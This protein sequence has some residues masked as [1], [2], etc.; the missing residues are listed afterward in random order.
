VNR[1][2]QVL[3]LPEAQSLQGLKVAFGIARARSE[4]RR[5][6]QATW[7]VPMPDGWDTSAGGHCF[8]NMCGDSIGVGWVQVEGPATGC[9]GPAVLR[10]AGILDR[11]QIG[12]IARKMRGSVWRA[13]R[14]TSNRMATLLHG[15][16]GR[17]LARR[18]IGGQRC[19]RQRFEVSHTSRG[20]ESETESSHN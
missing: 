18:S 16:G 14:S 1:T 9:S 5:A 3:A 11:G 10:S 12:L 4:Y 15:G 8:S 20:I 13:R 7:I 6:V 17:A 19:L 2:H